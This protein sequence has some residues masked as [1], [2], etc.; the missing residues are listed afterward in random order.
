M[1]QEYKSS[2]LRCNVEDD[3]CA[4]CRF[5]NGDRDVETLLEGIR[6]LDGTLAAKEQYVRDLG[7][8]LWGVRT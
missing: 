2:V 8:R 6:A 3:G 4:V 1:T 5:L 7:K